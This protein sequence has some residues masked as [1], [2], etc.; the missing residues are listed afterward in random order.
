MKD[1]VLYIGGFDLPDGNAAA[2]RARSNAAILRML[3]Y[4]T[5]IVGTGRCQRRTLVRPSSPGG[6]R[7]LV[8]VPATLWRINPAPTIAYAARLTQRRRVSHVICY[9]YPSVSQAVIQAWCKAKGIRFLADVTEWNTEFGRGLLHG[10]VRMVEVNTR[11][12]VL[13]RFADALITTSQTMTDYYR[14]T[15]LPI[16]QLPT[17]F[18]ADAVKPPV[19]KPTDG[20]VRL[21]FVGPGFDLGHRHPDSSRMKERTDIVVRMMAAAAEINTGLSCDLYGITQEQYLHAFPQD[22]AMLAACA[23]RIVFHGRAPHATIIE[24]LRNADASVILR[25]NK[26]ANDAGFPTKFAES[27]TAGTPVV[28]DRIASLEAYWGHPHA[29]LVE[30]AEPSMMACRMIDGLAAWRLREAK[31]PSSAETF[32]T[33]HYAGFRSEMVKAMEEA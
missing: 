7:H 9:N 27:I 28:I 16:A 12:M 15:G 2:L 1:L 22:K 17:L 11:I 31:A 33:F 18:D 13:N 29:I 4:D 14:S 21:V 26:R 10:I 32:R 8:S 25:D 3:G 5:R 23:G 6:D 19:P 24:A 30:R 20:A